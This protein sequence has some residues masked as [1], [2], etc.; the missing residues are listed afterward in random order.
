MQPASFTRGP[1]QDE[2]ADL[3]Q[4]L[5]SRSLLGFQLDASHLH[6]VLQT[7]VRN[8]NQHQQRVGRRLGAIE[9]AVQ[10]LDRR[11]GTVEQNA[12]LGGEGDS[13]KQQL[14]T[15][16]QVVDEMHHR[17]VPELRHA[18]ADNTN[19][20]GGVERGLQELGDR[21]V[22]PLEQAQS[23]V[24]RGLADCG[25]RVAKLE[26]DAGKN[27]RAVGEMS[28]RIPALEHEL[29]RARDG[30]DGLSRD[31]DREAH[32]RKEAIENVLGT[33]GTAGGW[34]EALEEMNDRVNDNFHAVEQASRAVDVELTKLRTDVANL[35]VELNTLDNNTRFKIGKVSDDVD[36]KFRML[37]DTLRAF[38]SNSA[39]M[40]ETLAAA[41]R[42][43]A[44]QRH[45]AATA[46]G[47]V[48]SPAASR[49]SGY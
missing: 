10:D 47:S 35:R 3:Q 38:E 33:A 8:Q 32:A 23:V 30:I 49:A 22:R 28:N 26:R 13:L 45:R 6:D 43:L 15:I 16:R 5:D 39:Q 25:G 37:L 11:V 41:G 36:E 12:F 29:A 34:R 46:A 4:F 24:D 31:L 14:T 9:A 21:R 17:V 2:G 18:I 27:D 7:I 19:K 40:E 1:V 48:P 20:C 44:H 42:A